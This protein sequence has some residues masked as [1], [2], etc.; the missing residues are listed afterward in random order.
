MSLRTLSVV[1]LIAAAALAQTLPSK[2]SS[3]TLAGQ[4]ALGDGEKATNVRLSEVQGVAGDGAGGFY[5]C[6]TG[7]HRIRFVGKDGIIS[8][9]AGG[10]TEV[11]ND[12]L[13]ANSVRLVEPHGIVYDGTRNQI[14]FSDSSL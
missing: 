14:L 9:I 4:Y 11:P 12:G 8:T 1:F 6:E 2:Y 5:F 3:S 7:K 10:G 13:A